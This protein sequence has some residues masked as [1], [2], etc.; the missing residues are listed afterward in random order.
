MRKS[1]FALTLSMLAA[2]GFIVSC[3]GGGSTSLS[4]STDTTKTGVL[5]DAP[6]ANVDYVTSSGLKGTTDEQGHF[7]YREGDKV[8]FKIANK[9]K[10]GEVNG[11]EIVT[12]VELSGGDADK[13]KELVALLIALDE[14]GNPDD[15]IEVSPENLGIDLESLDTEIDLS[16]LDLLSL[17][18]NSEEDDEH[19]AVLLQLKEKIEAHLQMAEEHLKEGL[20]SLLTDVLT[21][22]DGSNVSWQG[23]TCAVYEV[24]T[25]SSSPSLT[26]DCPD[27]SVP[28][29]FYFDENG[30][31]VA[32][33]EGEE[34]KVI[35]IE[36]DHICFDN[37][38]CLKL[39]EH[40][41]ESGESGTTSGESGEM[42]SGESGTTSGES[43]EMTSGE[44]GTTSG[45]SEEMTSGE[46]GTTSGESEEM[47][48]GE[49]GTTSG[50]SEEMTSGESGTTSGETT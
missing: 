44:S 45:E 18:S 25:E 47:T 2:G 7:Q 37:G 20:S 29:S 30:L 49:S 8:A 17:S 26:L 28:I 24:S 23:E 35:D 12:P 27:G 32:N 10:L 38:E 1:L 19:S 34:H 5:T 16:Q 9:I 3:G 13:L 4:T 6:I 15:G 11:Q 43:E 21:N 14:D 42:T 31:L 41:E 50:E 36:H 39:A 33:I 48:S 22:F 40:E 46:S